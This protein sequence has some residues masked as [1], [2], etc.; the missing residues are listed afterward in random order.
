M[1]MHVGDSDPG[2]ASLSTLLHVDR[3]PWEG[4]KASGTLLIGITKSHSGC[5]RSPHRVLTST[6]LILLFG[7]YCAYSNERSGLQTSSSQTF[8]PLSS[9]KGREQKS[10]SITSEVGTVDFGLD[11]LAAVC[12][13][14]AA[15]S[16]QR[17]RRDVLLRCGLSCATLHVA[18]LLAA[19]R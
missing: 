3:C 11:V 16:L 15:A 19:T 7:K 9:N 5:I 8:F 10:S 2:A 14:T 6:L 13:C 1:R 4:L 18:T 17:Q 12:S